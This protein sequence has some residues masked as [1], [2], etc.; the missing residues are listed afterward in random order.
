MRTFRLPSLV[1]LATCLLSLTPASHAQPARNFLNE[2]REQLDQ[3]MAWFNDARFGMFIHW[4]VYAV[5]AGE[6]KER[7]NLGEW[8]LEE[9]KMP[10]SDYVKFADQFNPAQFDAKAWVA[11]AK[12]AGMKYLVIT[13]KHHDGFG[14]WD[15]QLT[16]W[17][18]MRTPFK[19]DILKELA[20]ACE[21]AGIRFC[22]YHSIMDWHH[23]D[24]GTRR[25]YNDLAPATPPDMDRYTTYM[26][27]QL[28]ELL[29]GYGKLGILWFDGEWES[30]WNNTRGADLYNFVRNLQPEIIINNR[31]GKG[32]QGMSGMDKGQGVGDYGTPEQEIPAAGF[33]KGVYWESCMTMNNHWGYN[34]NDQNWK[35]T[36]T[37]I[38][39]L[40]DCASKGGNYL[41]NVGPTAEGLIPAP[42]LERLAEMGVWMKVN[43]E[44][45]YGTS[46]S[47]FSK[48]LSW[49]R[50]TQKSLPGG[51]T[52]LFLCVYDW[53][54]DGKLLLTG[55]ANQPVKAALLAGGTPLQVSAS[56]N[57]VTVAVPAEA[58]DR[59]ASVIA[60][61][62]QG[63]PEV[64]TLDPYENETKE[65]RDARMAWFRDA[66]FGMFIHWGVYAVP[67]GTYGTNR[68]GGI[69]EWIMN[70]GKIPM[71]EY[72]AYAKEFNPTNYDAD[73]WVK[74]AKEAGMKY[75]VITSKH[76]D[77]FTLF[78]SQASNWGIAKATP[79]GKDLLE[80]LAAACRK[81]GLKL[82]FYYSQAQDWNNGG[83]AAGGKWDKAQE[84][85]MDDYIDRIAV[86]QVKEILTKYG[87]FPAILWWDTPTDMNQER[88]DKLIPLLKLKPGIVHN[89][90]LGGGYKGDTETP[91]QYIPATGYPGGRDFEVCMTMNDTWGFKSYDNKWKSVE[92]LLRNLIDIASKGGNYL[93]NVGP[94][95]DGRIPDESI[96]RLKAVGAWMKVNGDAIYGTTP[97]PFKR[98]PWG[99]ATTKLTPSGATLYLSV[100]NWPAAG[101]L[102][103]PGLKNTVESAKLLAIGAQLEVIASPE[104]PVIVVPATAP[105]AIASVIALQIKGAPEVG[106]TPIMQEADGT[107]RLMAS[108]AELRGGL[109]YESGGGKDNIGYW[110]NPAD[111]ASW[112]FKVDRPGKFQVTAE[113]ASQ[114][115]GKF[116]VAVGSAKLTGTAPNTGDYTRFRRLNLDGSLDIASAGTVTLTVKPVKEGWQPLNL[117]SLTL[118]PAK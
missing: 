111:T 76:H 12:D 2:P 60:L 28:K 90:R 89:D 59:V 112:T 3:R 103:V 29:T 26:K 53:P 65:Q 51:N 43:R 6:Y 91:E 39:N 88:A 34:K 35:S 87:E 7:K 68:I 24:W 49:G 54:K 113:I 109:Q 19:R 48:Q 104:G 55:L 31:V 40:I 8:Y 98:L 25:A 93:L 42:S 61:D 105:D 20:A 97:S 79:Y 30:P 101:K 115:A 32:R 44:A 92:T 10:V 70:R 4:G 5:P 66:R 56:D 69:G 47:P 84:Y 81:Y 82:G 99:R 77:G 37:L 78:E 95:A 96:E 117:K 86:P 108:E 38:R 102:V 107:V 80:P 114:G 116:E 62:L 118:R 75:I 27:G 23:P 41:L 58:P 16:D 106:V 67:A 11:A 57:V 83:S 21:A 110:T 72:Q 9:S 33:G 1:A 64:V 46:A 36:Q 22:L 50:C 63:A 94:T 52:R 73:A 17:D 74:L 14:L 15:S 100:F 45:I 18:I 85:S 13:S 71:A